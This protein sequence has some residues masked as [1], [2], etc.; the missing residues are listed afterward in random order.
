MVVLYQQCINTMPT[1]E[2]VL[3]S[4]EEIENDSTSS[5]HLDGAIQHKSGNKRKRTA[6]PKQSFD[7]RFDDLMAFKAKYGHYNV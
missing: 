2:M 5:V 7:D 6:P 3:S 1:L 4:D